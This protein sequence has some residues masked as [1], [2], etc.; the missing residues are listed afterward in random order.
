MVPARYI[1]RQAFAYVWGQT[2]R[3]SLHLLRQNLL[4]G[5]FYSLVLDLS[6]GSESAFLWE[7]FKYLTTI[8]LC[9]PL[10][11]QLGL[12]MFFSAHGFLFLPEEATRFAQCLSYSAAPKVGRPGRAQWDEP[13]PELKSTQVTQA[14][15][16]WAISFSRPVMLWSHTPF[17]D[18]WRKHALS[19]L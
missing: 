10:F 2:V 9:N 5:S 6:R 14:E 8:G 18:L 12:P 16:T 7:T 19:Q 3:K 1:S 15:L 4:P 13:L 17:Q 11:L